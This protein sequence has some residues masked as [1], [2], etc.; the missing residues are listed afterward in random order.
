MQNLQSNEMKL[1]GLSKFAVHLVRVRANPMQVVS[2]PYA[3]SPRVCSTSNI[4]SMTVRIVI[5]LGGSYC[6]SPC[7]RIPMLVPSL[8]YLISKVVQP[9]LILLESSRKNYQASMSP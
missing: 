8:V 9:K 2:S 6:L 3:C 5:Y 4:C 7:T 1:K